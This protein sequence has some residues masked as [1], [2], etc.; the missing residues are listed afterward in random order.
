MKFYEYLKKVNE[1]EREFDA[2]VGD[3]DM[4][5]TYVG[6]KNIYLDN[7]YLRVK[8]GALLDAEV[9]IIQPKRDGDTEVC[10]IDDALVDLGVSFFYAAAGYV[11]DEEYGKEQINI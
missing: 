7:P 8:Y 6:D 9:E 11:S 1:E 2:C 3:V 4:P 10:V 5:A